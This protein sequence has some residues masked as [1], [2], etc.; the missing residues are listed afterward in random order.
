MTRIPKLLVTGVQGF[1]A[2]SVSRA[3]A[4]AGWEVLGLMRCDS[5]PLESN[6]LRNLSIQNII[7]TNE[8]LCSCVEAFEPD[9][10]FHGAGTA[11]V[12]HSLNNPNDDFSGSVLLFQTLLEAVRTSGLKPHVM[13]P[14]SAAVYG[15]RP[16]R[17]DEAAAPA[18]ISPYGF[19]K[20]QCELLARQ[21]AELYGIPT[22]VMRLFSVFGPRQKKLLVWEIFK[23]ARDARRIHL[24]GTGREVRDY[25][26][27]D[28]LA[29]AVLRL[30][31]L[32]PAKAAGAS[33]FRLVNLAS[34]TGIR[35]DKVA[36]LVAEYI[37]E[38]TVEAAGVPIQ[39]D[40]Q[41][42]V[43]DTTQLRAIVKVL[44]I[45][46]FEAALCRCLDRWLV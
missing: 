34:G 32:P 14:S 38:T 43:A 19:H 45:F 40:P 31:V 26:P 29:E 37:G 13:Y 18:P 33:Y 6:A 24:R 4:A 15:N 9:I 8:S 23:Q 10:I 11:S 1:I 36:Q 12:G 44:P 30:A 25:L 17:L 35:I 42:L 16:H 7:Y 39:G 28:T 22:T 46:N 27:D 2:H 41:S 21:Y 5:S 3:F 20:W